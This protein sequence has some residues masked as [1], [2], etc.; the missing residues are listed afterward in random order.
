MATNKNETKIVNNL[1]LKYK[2][3][4][5]VIREIAYHPLLFFKRKAE[6]GDNKAVRI[7]YWGAFVPKDNYIS[8]ER[9]MIYM[10]NTL[11]DNLDTLYKIMP[12]DYHE[13]L[14]NSIKDALESKNKP[15][16]DDL[17]AMYKKGEL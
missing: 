6:S 8:K 16:L 17:Y 14:E 13:L 4:K 11:L 3:D 9:A 10:A 15:F 2:L 7:M 12:E 1:S 5:R